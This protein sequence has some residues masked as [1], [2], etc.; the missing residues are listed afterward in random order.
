MFGTSGSAAGRKL[1]CEYGESRACLLLFCSEQLLLLLLPVHK[2]GVQQHLFMPMAVR[3]PVKAEGSVC[4]AQNSI[5]VQEPSARQLGV[6][7]RSQL[8]I[9]W[10]HHTSPAL[11]PVTW[12]IIYNPQVLTFFSKLPLRQSCLCSCQATA[13]LNFHGSLG[14]LHMFQSCI[15]IQRHYQARC[16]PQR[17]IRFTSR[18]NDICSSSVELSGQK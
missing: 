9:V 18:L 1:S 10:L 2:L 17:I 7:Y 11:L 12:T 14:I 8:L 15:H 3:S 6:L 16:E 13:H 5:K 4:G